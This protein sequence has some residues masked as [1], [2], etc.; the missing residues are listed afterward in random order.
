MTGVG[1]I[2]ILEDHAPLLTSIKPST[3]YVVYKDSHG[4]EKRDDFAV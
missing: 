2:T 3:M 1:E 4:I